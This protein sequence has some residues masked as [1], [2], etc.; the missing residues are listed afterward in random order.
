MRASPTTTTT[1]EMAHGLW[2]QSWK[3]ALEAVAK[4]T[5]TRILSP[6]A[7][8]GHQAV[9]VAERKLVIKELTLLTGRGFGE[10]M[11]ELQ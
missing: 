7:A 3:A 4:A 10:P 5:E 1:L 6:G 2:I 9:I 11:K 8:A